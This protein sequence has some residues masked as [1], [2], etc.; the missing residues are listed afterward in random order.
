MTKNESYI[1]IRNQHHVIKNDTL[2]FTTNCI[3][4][5]SMIRKNVKPLKNI[6]NNLI[7][8][9]KTPI[10]SQLILKS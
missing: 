2:I 8:L 10:D 7:A 3:K 6:K 5:K 4:L 1:N 9:K